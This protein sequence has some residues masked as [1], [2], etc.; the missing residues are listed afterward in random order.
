MMTEKANVTVGVEYEH[1]NLKGQQTLPVKPDV[2]KSFDMLL[3]AA[4]LEYKFT[5]QKSLRIF[6][7]TYTRAPSV[8][9]LQRVLDNSNELQLRSGNPN[10]KQTFN[11][12]LFLNYNQTSLDKG[13]TFFAM[14]GGSTTANNISSYTITNNRMRD[15]TFVDK[16]TGNEITLQQGSQYSTYRNMDGYYNLLSSATLGVPINISGFKSN[17]NLNAGLGFSNRPGFVNGLKNTA[18]TTSPSGG[19]TLSSNISE[20]IDFTLSH[21]ASYDMVKNELVDRN[22]NEFRHTA[23]FSGTWVTWKDITLRSTAAYE[24]RV[25]ENSNLE[26]LRI[27]AS[28]GKK[29]LKSKNAELRFSVYDILNQAKSYNRRVEAEYVE[30][31]RNRILSRY[32]MLSFVYTLRNFGG[33]QPPQLDSNTPP[34]GERPRFPGGGGPGGGGPRMIIRD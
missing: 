22:D 7:S 16:N 5:K 20:K 14:L 31:S 4:R 11:Q 29:F 27:D 9:E 34:G 26:F 12:R 25:S 6:Y 10:L 18:K 2:E 32:F 13:I 21:N 33:Q 17:L 19:A 23:N 28:L 3:P 1:A 8:T 24:Q 15:T 30:D